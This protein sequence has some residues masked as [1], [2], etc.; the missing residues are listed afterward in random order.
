MN[1]IL[2]IPDKEI[3]FKLDNLSIDQF[4]P[5]NEVT[6]PEFPNMVIHEP[7]GKPITLVTSN[8]PGVLKD[9]IT[10]IIGKYCNH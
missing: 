7:G 4:T 8:M 10:A 5:V 6:H 3:S 2:N 9:K 1:G